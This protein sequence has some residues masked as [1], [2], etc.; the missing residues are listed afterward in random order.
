MLEWLHWYE[1]PAFIRLTAL[2]LAYIGAVW[3]IAAMIGEIIYL[4]A[5]TAFM[6]NFGQTIMAY[7]LMFTMPTL[8]PNIAI[9]Y[10][11][12]SVSNF[13]VKNWEKVEHVEK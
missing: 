10:K 8:V 2:I 1:G 5:G 7:I 13:K 12:A 3:W 11:E 6:S 9:I 4:F